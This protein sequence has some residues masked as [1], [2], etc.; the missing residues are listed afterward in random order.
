MTYTECYMA[1]VAKN[2]PT[3]YENVANQIK[4]KD[5]KTLEAMGTPS[6]QEIFW[7]VAG[8][9]V[10]GLGAYLLSRRF[11]RDASKRQ[12]A[13]DVA[14]GALLGLGGTQLV[15]N[16][17]GDE[18]SGLSLKEMMRADKLIGDKSNTG[19]NAKGR[20]NT[21]RF[22]VNKGTVTGGVLGGVGGYVVGDQ[23]HWNGKK[24]EDVFENAEIARQLKLT[25]NK[26]L[27]RDLVRDK[28]RY[29]DTARAISHQRRL[30]GAIQRGGSTLGGIGLGW[31]VGGALHGSAD[32]DLAKNT[33]GG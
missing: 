19:D 20:E 6:G 33:I 9:G 24:L 32:Q 14:I 23:V 25:Q 22:G 31:L 3:E 26:K 2:D 28:T 1:K 21:S 10:G 5:E 15:L 8:A 7:N 18:K 11:R 4:A 16:T 30:G 13:L 27:T 17:A 29:P 12:R